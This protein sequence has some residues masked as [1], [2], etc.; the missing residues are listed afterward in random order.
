MVTEEPSLVQEAD[1]ALTTKR[2]P[3][4]LGGTWSHG[5]HG[6]ARWERGTGHG[7]CP[8][9]L[10]HIGHQVAKSVLPGHQPGPW[11]TCPLCDHRTGPHSLNGENISENQASHGY[12]LGCHANAQTHNLGVSC[13]DAGC[14]PWAEFVGNPREHWS[15]VPPMLC[16]FVPLYKRMLLSVSVHFNGV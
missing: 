10:G 1:G 16:T 8:A 7:P 9:V 3:P 6:R 4:E 5:C 13:L 2:T 11:L 15:G 12:R 14:W